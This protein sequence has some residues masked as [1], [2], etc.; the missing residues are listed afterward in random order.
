MVWFFI[1]LY[2]SFDSL[3][4]LLVVF[5][6]WTLATK[7]WILTT[8]WIFGR[9]QK[10]SH[11]KKLRQHVRTTKKFRMFKSSGTKE[12]NARK[13]REIRERIIT[14]IGKKDK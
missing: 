12:D 7:F 13:I 6:F 5:T 11:W 3:K 8:S 14:T 10:K 2:Q 4:E 1:S 9:G